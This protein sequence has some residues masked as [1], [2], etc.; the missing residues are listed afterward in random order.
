MSETCALT[1][2]HTVYQNHI[3][4][5]HFPFFFCLDKIAAAA[6]NGGMRVTLAVAVP[7]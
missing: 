3:Y 7:F 5:R 4:T 1:R 6:K 2:I